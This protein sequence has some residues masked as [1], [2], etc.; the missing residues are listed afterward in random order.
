MNVLLTF[1]RRLFSQYFLLFSFHFWVTSDYGQ[2]LLFSL[3][4]GIVSV[5]LRESPGVP[6]IRRRS[7][8]EQ[9]T[10]LH[11]CTI[12]IV[13]QKTLKTCM[14]LGSKELLLM[15][16]LLRENEKD[17]QFYR[18]C[19]ICTT[20]PLLKCS[21]HGSISFI[22]AYWLRWSIVHGSIYCPSTQVINNS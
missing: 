1:C 4:S 14:K 3:Y 9:G 13:L 22:Y 20:V 18:G 7:A 10:C 21:S 15:S 6:S 16:S 5:V 2:L 8:A 17:T 12:I 11:F 19:P